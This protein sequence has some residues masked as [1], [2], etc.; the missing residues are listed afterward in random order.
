[1]A[2]KSS[3]LSEEPSSCLLSPLWAHTDT[4][5]PSHYHKG[6]NV[7]CAQ[8]QTHGHTSTR[9]HTHKALLTY[10]HTHTVTRKQRAVPGRALP[11]N[12]TQAWDG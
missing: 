6:Y 4:Q 10:A 12:V 1:M 11:V 5:S 2:I 8:P 7:S 9:A 3:N